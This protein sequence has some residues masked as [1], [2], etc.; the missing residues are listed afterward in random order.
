MK[1]A[2]VLSEKTIYFLYLL[3]VAGLVINLVVAYKMQS[4]V[5]K[6]GY[7]ELRVVMMC[8]VLGPVGYLYVIAL[9]DLEQRRLLERIAIGISELENGSEVVRDNVEGEQKR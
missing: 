9:P 7:K 4:V 6:K 5:E 8:F 2:I 3:I 1:E